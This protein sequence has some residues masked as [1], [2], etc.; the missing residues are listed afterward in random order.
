MGAGAS[1]G[2]VGACSGGYAAILSYYPRLGAVARFVS[3]SLETS[4][5]LADAARVAHLSPKYFSRYF[6]VRMGI[7]FHEWLTQE[8]VAKSTL[9]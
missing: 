3:E 6:K 7:G 2:K 4:I 5:C 9:R 1:Q 8:R